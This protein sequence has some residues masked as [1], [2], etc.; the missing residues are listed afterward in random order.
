MFSCCPTEETNGQELKLQQI[1][2]AG[3][4]LLSMLRFP[5]LGL[6]S[7]QQVPVKGFH[8]KR[9]GSGLLSCLP[10]V[11]AWPSQWALLTLKI[12]SVE[13]IYHGNVTGQLSWNHFRSLYFSVTSFS[14]AEQNLF[15]QQQNPLLCSLTNLLC[16]KLSCMQRR[17]CASKG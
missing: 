7:Q 10:D 15:K 8:E 5:A 1:N 9:S 12:G 2:P 13:E 6:R 16:L 4:R 14:K 11:L 3:K 17:K